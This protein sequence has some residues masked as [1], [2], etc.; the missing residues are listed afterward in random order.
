MEKERDRKGRRKKKKNGDNE[1]WR[2][3]MLVYWCV[4]EEVIYLGKCIKF[5]RKDDI[6]KSVGYF[7]RYM[8]QV[9]MEY[10]DWGGMRM[11]SIGEILILFLIV[12]V[13]F[14]MYIL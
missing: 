14:Y 11:I 9:K 5:Q 2:Q 7:Q 13:Y 4:L 6:Q 3:N 12:R 1:E 10:R 8:G